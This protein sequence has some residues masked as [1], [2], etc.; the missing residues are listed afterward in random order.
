[1]PER[2]DSIRQHALASLQKRRIPHSRDVL[3]PSTDNSAIDFLHLSSKR[4]PVVRFVVAATVLACILLMGFATWFIW[5]TREAQIAQTQVATSNI[6]RMVGAQIESAMKTTGMALANVAER[7]EFDGTSPAALERLQAH[8]VELT[9]TTPELHGIF[10]Y[11][12]DGAWL[13]TSL[14]QPIQANNADRPY[15]QYHRDRPGREIHV[16]HPV[17]SRSTGV[18]VCPYRAASTIPTAASPVSCWSR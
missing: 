13:A 1:M 4:Q 9:R 11:G 2:T 10:V 5:T 14:G 6:A 15:F 17:R 7:V 12:E 18:W 8:L 16:A 3:T